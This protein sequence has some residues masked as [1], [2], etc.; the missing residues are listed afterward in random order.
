MW[1]ELLVGGEGWAGKVQGLAHALKATLKFA[2]QVTVAQE[3]SIAY[4]R[5]VLS[6]EL[7]ASCHLPSYGD[8]RL[9]KVRVWEFR[10]LCSTETTSLV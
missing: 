7:K 2:D 5:P 9:L 6:T 3:T 8:G 4:L 1:P 10:G